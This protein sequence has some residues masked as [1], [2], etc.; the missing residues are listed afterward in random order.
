M[1]DQIAHS[2][3]GEPRLCIFD[4]RPRMNAQA[5][6]VRGGGFEDERYYPHIELS[7]CDIANIHAVTNAHQGMLDIA[8]RPEVFESVMA[9]GPEVE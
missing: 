1:L 9:Y 4:A 2:G 7:F 5:N 6:R 8:Q 3:V